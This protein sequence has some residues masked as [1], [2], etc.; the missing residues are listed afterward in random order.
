MLKDRNKIKKHKRYPFFLMILTAGLFLAEN[1]KNAL[2]RAADAVPAQE[3]E[4]TV[5]TV[6]S[7]CDW[8]WIH[9]RAWHE[10]RYAEAIRSYLMFM[11]DYPDYVWQLETVNEETLP[12]LAKAKRDWPGLTEEFWQRIREGRIEIVSGYSNPRI[13]EVYP[14]TFVR[15]LILGKEFFQQYAANLERKLYSS[16]DI[17]S[18]PAQ[19]PQILSQADYQYYEFQRKDGPQRVFWYKGLDGTRMLYSRNFALAGDPRNPPPQ[20]WNRVIDGI[21]PVPVW[22]IGIGNDDAMP[23]PE[24]A[25]LAA[26]W[27]PNEKILGTMTRYFAECEKYGDQLSELEGPLDSLSYFANAGAYGN[28]NIY[29]QNNQNEDLLLTLEKAQ[30]MAALQGRPFLFKSVRPLWQDLLSCSGHAVDWLFREDYEERMSLIHNTT[31]RARRLLEEAL[32]A[33][34]CAVEFDPQGGTPLPVF[35]FQAWPVSGPVEFYVDEEPGKLTLRDCDDRKIPMQYIHSD[36][37]KGHCLSFMAEQVPACGYK[38][39]YLRHGTDN[40]TAVPAADSRLLSIENIWYRLKMNSDGKVEIYD[41]TNNEFLAQSQEVGFGD[42]AIYDLPPSSSW[43]HDGPVGSR[44]N[45][46]VDMKRSEAITGPVYS[47]LRSQGTIGPHQI[48]REVR[49]WQNSQRIEYLVEIDAKEDNGIL[50]VR[51]PVGDSE[52]AVAG[53]FFG[54]ES[55][56]NLAA[57]PFRGVSFS[58]GYPDGFDATRWTDV[59][60]ADFGYTF[61]CPPGTHTGYSFHKETKTLEFVLLHLRTMPVDVFRSCH[62]LLQGKGNHSWRFALV[63]HEGSW[64]Q[65]LSYR[66]ALEQHVPLLAYSPWYNLSRGGVST[67]AVPSRL[68]GPPPFFGTLPLQLEAAKAK[69]RHSFVS[70]SPSNVILSSMRLIPL[71]DGKEHFLYELRLYET[72]GEPANVTIQFAGEVSQ[73]QQIN[74]LGKPINSTGQIRITGNEIHFAMQPWKIVTLQVQPTANK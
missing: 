67:E 27:D 13:S 54:V 33:I 51:F 50:C 21:Y 73:V 4:L 68:T 40:S 14:E 12:F 63:P 22:R 15:N 1:G 23:S 69:T 36:P 43:E 72:T 37:T 9:T 10:A 6:T 20:D 34:S 49:L 48:L 26:T 7:H 74:L 70:L 2:L 42:L 25:K 11:R 31:V 17:M 44:R 30:V 38:T 65:A 41:K 5:V 58:D 3:P 35:N 53:T 59:A 19:I 46:K 32:S 62:P 57:E 55:R 61:I 64:Q 28:Y 18:G 24:V 29:T 8:A 71:E 45:W 52:Q 39:F 16:I 47:A 56:N 60:N 66:H